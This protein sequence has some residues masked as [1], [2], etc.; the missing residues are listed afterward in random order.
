MSTFFLFVFNTISRNRLLAILLLVIILSIS[1]F[2]TS[3]LKFTEDISK[4]LPENEK[5]GKMSFVFKNSKLLEKLVFNIHFSDSTLSDDNSSLISFAQEFSKSL[6]N[7]FVPSYLESIDKT[8]DS[9]DMQKLYFFFHDNLPLFLDQDDYQYLD[10]IISK[11]QIEKTIDANY[12]LLAS[13]A[14][15]AT[16]KNIQK[17]PLHLTNIALSKLKAFNLAEGFDL[18]KGQIVSK[19]GNNILILATPVNNSNTQLNKELFIGID[20]LI[21][22]LTKTNNIEVSY[23][24]N[25]AI[26]LGNAERIKK[27]II[28]TVSLAFAIL[29]IFISLFFRKKR[30]FILVFLP[31][32]LGALVSLGFL[33]AYSVE[34]SAIALGIGSVLLGI[35]VDYAIHILSH[36]RQNS[37]IKTMFRDVSTPIAMSSITT[38]SA[39][40]SLLFINSKALNDLGIFAAVSVLAAAGFSLIVLPHLL[41]K[42]SKVE[43]KLRPNFIDKI[44]NWQLH[45]S[46]VLKIII[47]LVT[48][49]FWF[50]SKSVS[51]DADM[52]K[53][54]YLSEQLK[55]AEQD[56]NNITS[57]SLKTIYIV[58]PGKDIDEAL[59]NNQY[60]LEI[61]DSLHTIGLVKNFTSVNTILKPV[62]EQ[63]KLL[64]RWVGFWED[65][66]TQTE[67]NINAS[68]KAKGFKPN[69][70]KGF[71]EM[72]DKEYALLPVSGGNK[73]FDQIIQNYIIQTDTLDAVIN[74]LKV[75]SD[76]VDILK[77]YEAFKEK[78]N[79]WIVDKRLVTSEFMNIL[80]DNFNKLIYISMSLVFLILLIA[81]GR[82]ELTLITMI[83]VLIS[84]I[85]TVGIMGLFGISFNIFNII[86]LT[87]IFGL[88]IDYSIFV[89]RG[90]LQEYKF[91]HKE[92]GSY[93]VSVILSAITTLAGIGVLIFAKHPALKS[94]ALM[95]IIGIISVVI[96]NFVILPSVFNWLIKYKKGFRNRPITLLDFIFS[97]LAMIVFVL[98]AL[99]MTMLSFI[100]RFLPGN[101]D[102]KKLIFHKIFSKLTWVLIYQNFL[103]SK[104]IINPLGEDYSE[105]SIIIANHQSHIDLMLMMLLNPRVLIL[106]NRRNYTHPIYG[107]ALQYADFIPSDEGYEKVLEDVKP[108]VMKGY[109]L[110]IYPEGHRNDSGKIKRF[111]KGAFYLSEKLNIPILPIIIHGQNQLLKKSEL[112]LKRGSIRTKFLPKINLHKHKYGNNL[113][114]QT[115]GIQEYFRKEYAMVREE[116][117]TPEYYTDYVRKNYL[118][119]GPVLEWYTKIK[120]KLEDNYHVFNNLIPRK[121]TITDLGCGYGYLDYLLNL[122]SEERKITAV[123]Y[124]EQKITIAA[125]CAIKND[126]VKFIAAN[127]TEYEVEESDV[128]IL[129]DVLHYLPSKLQDQVIE[130]CINK[131][132]INGMLIIRDGDIELRKG[133]K[134]TKI[135]EFFSTNFGFNKAEYK[136]E[137][138]S[139]SKIREIATNHKLTFEEI[140]EAKHT[141]NKLFVLRKN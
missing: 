92:I 137:F 112:F 119:K 101:T 42:S 107:K 123:D 14:G 132:S 140:G 102:K 39:F 27:D 108:L 34:V 100:F 43:K 5:I 87:F 85:W 99:F 28:L 32:G 68:A 118:Y 110:V 23:F 41:G 69:A 20:S 57:V 60:A 67:E 66:F 127:I 49:V 54:N 10:T 3:K 121:C 84:W 6:E 113:K 82:I 26:S 122:V 98:G 117:E 77:V 24:G 96:V 46:G 93:K 120:L 72:V 61:I 136:L 62:R 58:S 83:P 53:N 11:E 51:F 114:D 133:H 4:A 138:I 21:S 131:L 128:I 74:V 134:N 64:E 80:N 124:D 55:R 139:E 38:A 106:T 73:T 63:E 97:M 31:A 33:G 91:G 1:G 104:T 18:K 45:K 19:D 88:G 111:H 126:S 29:V 15:F 50:T 37:D 9:R 22:E 70:F 40:L 115:K 13:P 2:Y 7:K 52:M 44:A 47:I 81:Y 76:N 141:S 105:P 125:N 8:P 109:S 103:S 12:K 95:S 94:I 90:L 36:F 16:R 35:S 79:I 17:D 71:G 89:M 86:I 48:I 75:N 25:A 129:K 65:R 56:L 59:V 78:E 116:Y 135:T 30:S 130:N